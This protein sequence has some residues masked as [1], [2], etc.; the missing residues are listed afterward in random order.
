M[1][2]L[3]SNLDKVDWDMLSLNPNGIK[4]LEQ[5]P[6]RIY[7]SHLSRNPNAMG[8]LEQHPD[9]IAWYNLS[10]N[11]SIFEIDYQALQQRIA[12]FQEELIA[13]CFHPNRLVSYLE[14][15]HYDIGDEEY[16]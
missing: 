7:W 8:L 5:N 9:E 11:P 12:P 1:T 3:E 10:G 14:K 15:Y 2:L 16:I 4:L 13:Q 6:N